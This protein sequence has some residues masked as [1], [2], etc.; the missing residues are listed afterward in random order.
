MAGERSKNRIS[1]LP[2]YVLEQLDELGSQGHPADKLFLT[3]PVELRKKFRITR[4]QM[5]EYIDQGR[6]KLKTLKDEVL[7]DAGPGGSQA[8]GGIGNLGPESLLSDLSRFFAG[9]MDQVQRIQNEDMDPKWERLLMD[10]AAQVRLTNDSKAEAK[11]QRLLF[12]HAIEGFQRKFFR[13]LAALIKDACGKVYGTEKVN[14]VLEHLA[15]ASGDLAM[16]RLMEEAYKEAEALV[17]GRGN[18]NMEGEPS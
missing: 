13:E 17:A 3:V 2:P 16:D 6:R 4:A 8:T 18:P 14:E 10:L 11:K 5:Q 15:R 12:G 7:K 9:R 1:A